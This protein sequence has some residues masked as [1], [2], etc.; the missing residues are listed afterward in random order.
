M[1]AEELLAPW[2]SREKRLLGCWDVLW[3]LVVGF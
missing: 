1:A 3:S 2:H